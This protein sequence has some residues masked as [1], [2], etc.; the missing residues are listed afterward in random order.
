MDLDRPDCQGPS[1]V[2]LVTRRNMFD[3]MQALGL[4]SL[5]EKLNSLKDQIL[6]CDNFTEDQIESFKASFARFKS[7][8]KQRWVKA[9][10]KEDVFLKYNQSW[11]EG[12]IEIPVVIQKRPG[13]PPK[14][15][16]ESS[17]RTKRRKTEEIR[18]SLAKEFIIHAA[19]VELRKSGKRDASDILKEITTSSPL[20]ATKYKKAFSETKT[21]EPTQLAPLEALSMFVEADL[22][23]RQYK[24]I[25]NTNKKFFPCYSLLQ[26]EKQ[27]CYPPTE[28]CNVTNSSAESNL[29]ALVDLTVMR[30]STYLNEV[31]ITLREE[32]K[33]SLKVIC[34]W[35][36][37]GSQQCQFKQTFENDADSG[38]NIFQSCFV[39]LRL[40]CGK[41]GKNIVWENPTPSSPR[42]CRPIRFRFVKEST[43]VTQEEIEYIN[44]SIQGLQPTRVNLQEKE[45]LVRHVFIMTMVDGK[46]C[47]AATGTKSTSKCYICGATSK[48]FN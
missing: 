48:E 44:K 26:K 24:V 46:V 17:E 36:C 4:P 35:G 15:F 42:Y 28:E 14:M 3:R 31:L 25:R 23:R 30:L 10:K 29:Q 38:A 12:T 8:T 13:R 20:R 33:D 7:Q 40:V 37:D 1:G 21:K 34:K 27:K 41:E 11:L 16:E 19:Q 18:A 32:E 45:L 39:P 6:S 9:H 2:K 5:E 47:N 43:D 22:T